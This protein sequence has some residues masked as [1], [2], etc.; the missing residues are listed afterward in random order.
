[1]KH[2]SSSYYRF[3]LTIVTLFLCL[4]V[5]AAVDITTATGG[6]GISADIAQGSVAP[7]FTP[8]GDIVI[9]DNNISDFRPNITD[10]TLILTAPT[11]W[12][13]S[14]TGVTIN[15][16]GSSMITASS[17]IVNASTITITFTTSAATLGNSLT[18]SGLKVQGTV[19]STIA[20]SYIRRTGGTAVIS[21]FSTN[22][23][24]GTLT[25]VAG[26]LA[27]LQL[28]LPGEVAAPGTLAG[29][30]G[31][32]NS[33][34]GG[35]QFYVI[36]SSVDA[37]WNLVSTSR[38][39]KISSSDAQAD[40][41]T[42][43][44]TNGR[45]TNFPVTLR[46]TAK[47]ITATDLTNPSI[48][49][50]TSPT[51]AV[52]SGLYT[53]LQI[54][55]PGE[56]AAPGTKT[57][58]TGTPSTR[59]AGIAFSVTVNAV[60]ANWEKVTSVND[61]VKITS[62]E[63]NA[64]LPDSSALVLGT[65]T[66][67]VTLKTVITSRTLTARDLTD[68]GKIA[69]TSPVIT[70]IAGAINKLQV[71][72][73]GEVAAP[74]TSTGK[75]IATP[76]D[77]NA[78][79]AFYVTVRSVDENWNLVSSNHSIKITSS[80]GL[81]TTTT[82]ALVNG[83]RTSFSTTLR[84]LGAQTVTAT[85]LTNGAITAN[86]SASV[87]VVS[88]PFSKLQ[89]LLPGETAAPNTTTGKTGT[90]TAQVAGTPFNITVNAVNANWEIV[91]GAPSDIINI[92]STEANAILP[93][94][95]T[96]SFGTRV[97][98]VT[99][100][101][102]ITNRTITARNFSDPA[103]SLNVS[104]YV[105]ITAGALAK[106]LIILPGE[107]VAAGTLTGK[108]GTPANRAGGV[109]FTSTVRAV[110]ANWNLVSSNHTIKIT[111]SDG[112]ATVNS[113]VVLSGGARTFST[114]LR[115][116]GNQTVTASN[117]TVPA[118]SSYTSPNILV[119]SGAYA[120]LQILLPGENAAPGTSTGKT[121]AP[122]AQVAGT[123][124]NVTVNA[125]NANWEVDPGASATDDIKIT[126]TDPNAVI[127]ATSTLSSGTKI[128]SVVLK[129]ALTNRTITAT[130]T[131]DGTKTANTS[132]YVSISAGAYAK[133]QM[134]LPGETA[135]P[136]TGTGKLGAA[137]TPARNTAFTITVR[138]VD[139]NWNLRTDVTN[140]ITITSTDLSFTKPANNTLSGGS[141][142]FSV[143]LKAPGVQDVTATS[144]NNSFFVTRSVEETVPQTVATDY[145]RSA[146]S[147]D[148]NDV[149]NW[150]SS[151]NNVSWID[152]TLV[153]TTSS[154]GIVIK[155]GTQIT[156]VGARTVD[157]LLVESNAQLIVNP[158]ITLTIANGAAAVD[159]KVSG[160]LQNAGIIT[161]TGLLEIGSNG[162]YQHAYTATGGTIPTAT[163]KDL[164]TCEIIGYTSSA[165]TILGTNQD[166]YNFT[167][168][169]PDQNIPTGPLLSF[170]SATIRNNF[171]VSQTGL[172]TVSL[173][174]SGTSNIEN[175]IHND[176]STNLV[177]A[178]ATLNIKNYT[179]NDGLVN[180]IS[181]TSAGQTANINIAGSFNFAGGT[182]QKT[183]GSSLARLN[184]SG[185]SQQNYIKSGAADFSG[186]IQLNV[187]NNAIVNFG[188]SVFDGSTGS[189][190]N[191]AGSTLITSGGNGFA[192]TSLV[193]TIRSTGLRSYSTLA[194][195]VYNGSASQNTGDGLPAT[196]NNLTIN[197]ANGVTLNAGD[198]TIT[199]QL[200]LT[201]GNFDLGVNDLTANG[202][203]GNGSLFTQSI[204]ETPI[205]ANKTWLGTVFYNSSANQKI[206]D[207]VYNNLN[208]T[209]GTRTLFSDISISGVFTPGS[210]TSYSTEGSTINF[211]GAGD[212]SIPA[213]NF[214]NLSCNNGG[215]KT[216]VGS[217]T[218]DD[219]LNV[220][221]ST[222]L[223]A[224]NNLTLKASAT[225][226]ANVAPLLSGADLI[227]NV[228]VQSH[229][230]GAGS[231]GIRG[232]RSMSSPIN[233]GAISGDKTF[234]QLKN[235]IIITGPSGVTNG[236]DAGPKP[237]VNATSLFFYNEP[238]SETESAFLAVPS[239]N[240]VLNP[241]KGFLTFFRGNRDNIYATP[242]K[243]T[244]P[245]PSAEDVVVT[246]NGPINKGD[247]NI[248]MVYTSANT[249]DPFNGFF[250]AGN[251]YPATIDWNSVWESSYKMTSSILIVMGGKVNTT[252]NAKTGLGAN[253]GTRYIQPGQGFYVQA[254]SGGIL[255]FRESNKDIANS[256]VRLLS[257]PA[258]PDLKI[259]VLNTSSVM[260]TQRSNHA[261]PASSNK[262]VLRINLT[263]N[264]FNEETVVLFDQQYS[265]TA[266]RNDSKYFPGYD[267]TMATLS[268]DKTP[269]AINLMPNV[270]N[271]E[272]IKLS[273][274]AKQSAPMAM[275][276]SQMNLDDTNMWLADSYLGTLTQ[277]SSSTNYNFTVDKNVPTSFG[278]DRFKLI[279]APTPLAVKLKTFEVTK[280][281]KSAKL[282]WAT[283]S[284]VNNDKFE[285]EHSTNGKDFKKVGEVKGNGTSSVLNS[286]SF[287]DFSP[288]N[289]VNYY[290]LKQLDFNSKFDY[291]II[292]SVNFDLNAAM[293]SMY[294]NP[295][296]DVI[297]FNQTL[298]AVEI[299]NLQGVLVFQ[300]SGVITSVKIPYNLASGI[301][302]VKA[303]VLDG[304]VVTKR[305]MINK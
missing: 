176:G 74:G 27:K 5:S 163:W 86:V 245:F 278:D 239:I 56:T 291:S 39:I 144:T 231:G 222:T 275:S 84:T 224:N 213:F 62:N 126:S 71:L 304:R 183:T 90:P 288:E 277:V 67:S 234:K 235:Y 200:L 73:P 174:A 243:L 19:K 238:A 155:S 8:L 150:E 45:R 233:D 137:T 29:K 55:L 10:A 170:S 208:T 276:F 131:T 97:F 211:N 2:L 180:I 43:S 157:D 175:Y 251:P 282:S 161:T 252:Y 30:T 20:T 214:A 241:G 92:T 151:S 215:N 24:A 255:K 194:N 44:L 168:N 221:S 178:S 261:S 236:F 130:N 87:A 37:N 186:A 249:T 204:S 265:A 21:G 142:T 297:N 147:G 120:R 212:Q 207:G 36:V 242:G 59:T 138:A 60:N 197:N 285:I 164:S 57:G 13:F 228:K 68:G 143:N 169:C 46:T 116:L 303:K 123:P 293:L 247:V 148:F 160:I 76:S 139:A 283:V 12:Q 128:F 279:M 106:L 109:A 18:I 254:E 158:G 267:I 32:P 305:L 89:I 172:G 100:R 162:V 82:A 95:S 23:V 201:A 173:A 193:G 187:N 114:T 99:F 41:T 181:S 298:K 58:K 96:L 33:Q 199:N 132:S 51:V 226:N 34:N 149:F 72:L 206:V 52:T 152:A 121:G 48:T 38:S 281:S 83:S 280:T 110:D 124:F 102:A 78:G 289:G 290:R 153:P 118:V 302:M 165:N 220:G 28:L 127:L 88:G 54:L 50:N 219:V 225:S 125:V 25:Q 134:L 284:E 217:V 81:A 260:S 263:A 135:A 113:A 300:Q 198:L 253:G 154:N 156:I 79:V 47:T 299:Y 94:D 295:A 7:A 108:I 111:S 294:P 3:L 11:N 205:S 101:T 182:I 259:K 292:K 61:F 112:N 64:L 256:P 77:R 196:V 218:V 250:L 166:F 31:T 287:N 53:K 177:T 115:T 103:K 16:S 179:Q 159:L 271:V 240:T 266:D 210:P 184:F 70:I 75:T 1:M 140:T 209:G 6:V 202:S 117:T 93:S 244:A 232:T 63:V 227:G 188:T 257:N 203:V 274:L 192:A 98:S 122:N 42:A 171:T 258:Q 185:T 26:A 136:G 85:D 145:F 167:W 17:V 129:T 286:Y 230:S 246:Y 9:S 190:S 189:F 4:K 248:S 191:G 216:I 49:A 69:N 237:S 35:E 270:S 296:I 195:Y 40:V 301:Y 223:N 104:P 141:R 15:H 22:A 262:K 273:V 229:L 272:E 107:T 14:S 119:V 65:K 91:T 105:S 264:N 146:S 66:F 269:L 268:S 80:D 133:L